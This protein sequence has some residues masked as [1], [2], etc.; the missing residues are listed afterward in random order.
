MLNIIA[1][2]SLISL[3][4]FWQPLTK[5]MWTFWVLTT[6]NVLYMCVWSCIL[7]AIKLLL[8]LHHDCGNL[9]FIMMHLFCLGDVFRCI[10][11]HL[12]CRFVVVW[13]C[14]P[15]GQFPALLAGRTIVTELWRK[16]HHWSL[17]GRFMFLI[18]K[19]TPLTQSE[20]DIDVV[21]VPILTDVFGISNQSLNNIAG[22]LLIMA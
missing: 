2:A 22:G 1:A 5:Y 14:N 15:N 16:G 9:Q 3:G 6:V 20:V 21:V 7:L 4:F 13:Y 17:G 18:Q 19:L 12:V 11:M 8:L 10:P